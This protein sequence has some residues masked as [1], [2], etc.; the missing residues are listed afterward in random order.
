MDKA[1]KKLMFIFGTRPEVIKLASI[2]KMAKE[3]E[4]LK[5]YICST[6]QHKE[7]LNQT[8][9]SFELIPDI[10]LSLMSKNQSLPGFTSRAIV[11]I[12]DVLRKVKPDMV[13]VQGDTTTSFVGALTAFYNKIKI[14]HVEAGLRTYEKLNPFPEEIN[15]RMTADLA[16]YHFAPTESAKKALLKEGVL[17]KKVWVTGNTV[18]DAVEYIKNKSLNMREADFVDFPKEVVNNL[19]RKNS[20]DFILITCHRRENFGI[21]LSNVCKAIKTLS[22][23]YNELNFIFPVHFNP[24]VKEIVFKELGATDNIFLINP[25]DYKRFVRFM[26]SALLILTDSGGIQEEVFSLNIPTLVMRKNT[27]RFEGVSNGNTNSLVRL[28]GTDTSNIID[29]VDDIILNYK[30]IRRDNV[31]PFGDGQS[32]KRILDIIV[33]S[34]ELE[35]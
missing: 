11:K 15:R 30:K 28:V 9:E 23:N 32:S 2:I 3:Y 17:D 25:I 22:S 20:K 7:M 12:N 35:S 16:D 14:S 26:S 13:V 1:I 31:N 24:N 29:S 6:G 8:L 5:V 19:F 4:T 21:G 34:I 18:V 10:D 27:E 33:K